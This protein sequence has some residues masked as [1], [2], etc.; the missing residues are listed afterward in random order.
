MEYVKEELLVA[1]NN[2]SPLPI[3]SQALFLYFKILSEDC[4][5]AEDSY[6][7]SILVSPKVVRTSTVSISCSISATEACIS[8]HSSS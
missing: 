5:A 2:N 7:L 1:L 4:D 8:P 3:A 6:K